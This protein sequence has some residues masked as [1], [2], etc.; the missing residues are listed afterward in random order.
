M[1]HTPEQSIGSVRL[2]LSKYTTDTEVDYLLKKL[3]PI[4]RNLR[5][6]SPKAAESTTQEVSP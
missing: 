2:S 1:G 5:K 6:A 3:P 4:I